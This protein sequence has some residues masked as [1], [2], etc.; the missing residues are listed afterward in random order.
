M[1]ESCIGNEFCYIFLINNTILDISRRNP[2]NIAVFPVR[3]DIS[4][5]STASENITNI[6]QLTLFPS[7]SK[8]GES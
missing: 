2:N 4:R 1:L 8:I 5:W 6:T 3:F 7:V